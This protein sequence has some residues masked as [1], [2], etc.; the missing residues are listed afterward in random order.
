MRE[1]ELRNARSTLRRAERQRHLTSDSQAGQGSAPPVTPPLQPGLPAGDV[2]LGPVPPR[3]DLPHPHAVIGEAPPAVLVPFHI[4]AN[5]HE[6]A[7]PAPPLHT[8]H[9]AGLEGPRSILHIAVPVLVIAPGAVPPA[10]PY[11]SPN[12][13]GAQ[14]AAPLAVNPVPNGQQNSTIVDA[15]QASGKHYCP[16]PQPYPTYSPCSLVSGFP[17]GFLKKHTYLGCSM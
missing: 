15:H 11:P 14:A 4:H 8:H 9:V 16:Q 12:A 2:L 17:R 13:V 10:I 3:V 7:P 6:S 5:N 1:I